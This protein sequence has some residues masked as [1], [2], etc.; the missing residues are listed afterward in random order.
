[1]RRGWHS[2]RRR[3]RLTRV[4]LGGLL[5]VIAVWIAGLVW[6]SQQ[7]PRVVEEKARFAVT[8]A[9]V[10]LTGGAGRLSTGLDLLAKG[11]AGKLFVSGVHRGVEVAELLRVSRQA[12]DALDC[13]IEIGHDAT[14]T[15]ENARETAR[16]MAAQGLQSLLLVT[17]DYHMPRSYAEFRHA[18]PNVEM[19]L[20][21]VFADSVR[22]ENWWS[23]PRSLGLITS[24]FMKYLI[25]MAR[26]VLSSNE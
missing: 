1:M 15:A 11:Q 20:Y 25:G 3:A 22:I 21:P 16:W 4:V 24:E 14:N 10:V 13:C 26:Q 17:G 9:I 2:R 5:A 19:F 18:M 7:I 8:D 12:P 6:F 23:S